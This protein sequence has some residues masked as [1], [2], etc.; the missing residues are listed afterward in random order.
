MSP[1]CESSGKMGPFTLREQHSSRW[2][3]V[4]ICCILTLIHLCRINS[5]TV[6]EPEYLQFQVNCTKVAWI[7]D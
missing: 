2:K 1:E 7:T 5:V 3:V 4:K 6:N